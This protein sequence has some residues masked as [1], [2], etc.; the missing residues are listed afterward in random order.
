LHAKLRRREERVVDT[1]VG[2]VAIAKKCTGV[3]RLFMSGSIDLVTIPMSE[4]PV[5]K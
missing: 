5:K 3:L 1:G 2:E 4:T